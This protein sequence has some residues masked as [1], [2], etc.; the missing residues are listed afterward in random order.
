MAWVL[1][2]SRTAIADGMARILYVLLRTSRRKFC[3]FI[4]FSML[5]IMRYNDCNS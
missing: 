4:S 1:I 2:H 3:F 5:S